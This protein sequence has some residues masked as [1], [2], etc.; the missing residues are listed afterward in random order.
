MAY[1]MSTLCRLH[2]GC[3]TISFTP[4]ETVLHPPTSPPGHQA[5]GP[6]GLQ[7]WAAACLPLSCVIRPLGTFILMGPYNVQ[8]CR[9]PLSAVFSGLVHAVA[10]VSALLAFYC[11]MF[12]CMERP[13][14]TDPF[15]SFR[16]VGCFYVQPL[17]VVPL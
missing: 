11:Q 7:P 2:H 3:R 4:K 14:F 9:G 1:S 5:S 8:P 6:P 10:H 17:C 15:T 12:L 13:C 16:C